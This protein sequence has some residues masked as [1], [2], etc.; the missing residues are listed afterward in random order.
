MADRILVV[1]DEAD[2]LEA[3][4]YALTQEGYEVETASSAQGARESVRASPP[5][6]ILLD[7][8]LPD[9]DGVDLC[10]ELRSR[11]ELKDIPILMVSARAE[12]SDIISGLDRGAD[13]YVTKPFSPRQLLARIRAALRRERSAEPDPVGRLP[14][15]PLVLDLATHRVETEDDSFALTSTQFRLLLQLSSRPGK[16]FTRKQ[17]I[18]AVLDHDSDLGLRN[19]DSHIRAIRQKLRKNRRLIETV[20]GVGYRFHEGEPVP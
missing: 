3:L 12:E 20:R 7:L 13:D 14:R 10:E 11:R 19:I 6:L 18:D 15:G 16:V 1:D 17:L 4:T 8:R 2:I 9:G 5:D